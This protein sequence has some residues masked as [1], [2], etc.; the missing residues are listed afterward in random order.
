MP[1]LILIGCASLAVLAAPRASSAQ[2]CHVPPPGAVVDRGTSIDLRGEAAA[3]DAGDEIAFWQGFGIGA[4]WR[5]ARLRVRADVTAYR[6]DVAGEARTGI[7]DLTIDLRAALIARDDLEGGIGL[8]IG[9]P[10]GDAEAGLGMGHAMAMPALWGAWR[11]D[12][13][14]VEAT[15]FVHRTIGDV[16]IHVLHHHD[17]M[18]VEV[19]PMN[20]FEIGASTRLF[21]GRT[22]A[23][24][25]TALAAAPIGDGDFRAIVGGGVAVRPSGARWRLSAELL[26]P[27]AGELPTARTRAVFSWWL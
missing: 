24:Y 18:G 27:L 10:T 3:I 11:R 23:P 12:R 8:G 5:S 6:M 16:D 14:A 2:T 1:R 25:A 9:L 7:G 4:A 15:T 13:L 20:P 26:S 17:T 19:A 21:Y 22:I